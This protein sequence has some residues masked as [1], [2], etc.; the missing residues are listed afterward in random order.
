MPFGEYR[1]PDLTIKQNDS[2]PIYVY[3]HDT[4]N[5][6]YGADEIIGAEYTIRPPGG[7]ANGSNDI[8][9]P[10]EIKDDG[11]AYIAFNNT[12]LLGEYIAVVQFSLENGEKRSERRVFNVEDPFK[13][14]PTTAHE[15]IAEG[16]WV[17]LSD[18]F[19]STEGGPWLRDVTNSFFDKRKIVNIIND[20]LFDINYQPPQTNITILDFVNGG[21]TITD[22]DGSPLNVADP[23]QN[24]LVQGAL[25]STIR[26]LIR[27]YVE[28]PLPQGAQIVYEDRRDYLQR[29][30]SVL[31]TEEARYTRVLALWKRQFLGLGRTSLLVHSKAG[32]LTNLQPRSWASRRG[33]W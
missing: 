21:I 28:Q 1:R 2:A 23:D 32:R 22:I 16:V 25:I 5:V 18:L 31:Q 13:N 20:A 19:D 10:A 9:V 33:Y 26:H 4:E 30:Q 6:P 17:R 7:N 27:S 3:L 14:T 11:A 24:L 15:T 29:W 12:A 8:V